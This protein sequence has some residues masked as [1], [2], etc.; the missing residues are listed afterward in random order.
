MAPEASFDEMALAEGAFSPSEVTQCIKEVMEPSLDDVGAPLDFVYPVPGH[1]SMRPKPGFVVFVSFLS[2]CLLLNLSPN[3]LVL[4]LRRGDQP[5]DLVLMD[6]L[7]PLPRDLSVR[8][9]NHA[10]GERLKK[11]KEDKRKK[12]QWKL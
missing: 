9:V 8:A 4:T 1:P 11:A 12:R 10:E 2:S 6:H 5:R 3:P 7:A